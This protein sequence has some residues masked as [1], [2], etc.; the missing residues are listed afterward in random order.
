VTV[1]NISPIYCIGIGFSL[2]LGDDIKSVVSDT[3]STDVIA[4]DSE[5]PEQNQ[6]ERLEEVIEEPAANLL[7]VNEVKVVDC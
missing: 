4:S 2:S 1:R 7:G 5:P 6:L 3:W